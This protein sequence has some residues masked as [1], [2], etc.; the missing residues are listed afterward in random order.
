[1]SIPLVVLAVLSLTGGFIEL[2]ENMGPIH[3]FSRLFDHVLPV[4]ITGEEGNSELVFQIISA[5][6]SLGGVYI[7]YLL[8]YK[9]SSLAVRFRNSRHE[10]LLPVGMEIR[11][12]L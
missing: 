10:Q 8:F 2:P 4:V 11:Q 1:M 7:A 9:K 12:G 3:L 5:I 6:V